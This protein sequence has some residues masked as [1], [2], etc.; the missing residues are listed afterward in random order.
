MAIRITTLQKASARA[1][2]DINTLLV[3]LR[4]KTSAGGSLSELQKVTADTHAAMI[5]VK[6]DDRIVGMGTLYVIT[7]IGE[8]FG[9]VE[10]VVVDSQYRGKGLGEKIMRAIIERAKKQNVYYLALT[11]R[12][13]RA[14]ANKLYQKLGF[15]IK[16]TNIYR[17]YL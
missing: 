16:D 4:N 6:D 3:Q 13:E 9:F 14:A 2:K 5:V 8:K 1:L 10:D 11:S 12:P 17:L 15:E 7:K